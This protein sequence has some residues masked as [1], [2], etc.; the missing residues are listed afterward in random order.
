M[1]KLIALSLCTIATAALAGEAV[2]PF[3]GKNL[4]GWKQ[5]GPATKS[6]LTVGTAK[7][8]P[9]NTHEFVVGKGGHELINA[10][11]GGIAFYSE[12]VFGDAIIERM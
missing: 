6:H 3:N 12:A 1:K 2:K 7:L 11:G 4:D 5:K 8:N 10:K 9:K